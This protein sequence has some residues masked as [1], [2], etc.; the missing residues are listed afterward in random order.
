METYSEWDVFVMGKSGKVIYLLFWVLHF[1]N[2]I[3]VGIILTKS[4]V[5]IYFILMRKASIWI[6]RS[7]LFMYRY[8][9]IKD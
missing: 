1:K 6:Q 2:F 9:Y 3:R 4:T 5:F 8:I 7:G